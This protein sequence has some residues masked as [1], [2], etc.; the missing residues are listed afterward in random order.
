[1]ITKKKIDRVITITALILM[2]LV[3]ASIEKLDTNNILN[4]I[5]II[6]SCS[7]LAITVFLKIE[8]IILV[9]RGEEV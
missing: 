9:N 8:S 5:V 2:F 4:L 7:I 3:G 1:M 6:G